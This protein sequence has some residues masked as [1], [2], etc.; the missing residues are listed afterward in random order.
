MIVF[1]PTLGACFFACVTNCG[2]E[3]C[4]ELA[5]K[6]MEYDGF[7]V[8]R[9]SFFARVIRPSRPAR[10]VAFITLPG[11]AGES[12]E[13]A[14]LHCP[15]PLSSIS[16]ASVPLWWQQVSTRLALCLLSRL[17]F[18][19]RRCS[20]CCSLFDVVSPVKRRPRTPCIYRGASRFWGASLLASSP[21]DI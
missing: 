4:S 21:F 2:T 5:A 10:P 7:L 12:D 17:V 19:L 3:V 14:P 6:C 16:G 13:G 20:R 15:P 1:R 8:H 11:V 9:Y 18:V